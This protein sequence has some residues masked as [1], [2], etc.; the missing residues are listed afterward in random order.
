MLRRRI[1]M[2]FQADHLLSRKT[3]I[4]NI[5]LPITFHRKTKREDYE[6]ARLLL[7]EV[8]L[9]EY[10]NRYPSQLSGG[11]RQRVGIARALINKPEL[12]LCD[13]P[14]SALDVVTTT[15]ILKL[16]KRLA[17]LH[18][19][20]VI[21][22]T[23]DMHVIKEICDTVTVMDNG[24]IVETN[25]LDNILFKAKHPQTRVFIKEVGLDLNFIIEQ[26]NPKELLLLK[27]DESIIDQSII[28]S[29]INATHTDISI[30]YANVTPQRKGVMVLQV[31]D[32]QNDVIQFLEKHKVVVEHVI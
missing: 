25:T 21:I 3:V 1:G 29:M 9:S 18:H 16:I 24:H 10:A 14:T 20:D 30:V 23:H 2:I 13:E 22:V 31:P 6:Y 12:L 19:L 5:I 7:E 15:Q 11:Q 17:L 26:H 4:E 27:F 28:S 32:K 8:G